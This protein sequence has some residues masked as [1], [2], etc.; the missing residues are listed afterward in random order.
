M[1]CSEVERLEERV[2]WLKDLL[3]SKGLA[4]KKTMA[5]ANQKKG[6]KL[7]ISSTDFELG[8]ILVAIF[9][10]AMSSLGIIFYISHRSCYG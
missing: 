2:G 10:R 5:N 6:M 7:K 1:I 8:S 3:F 4:K 9:L